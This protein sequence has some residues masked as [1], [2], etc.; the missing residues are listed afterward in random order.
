MTFAGLAPGMIGMYQVDI[1]IPADIAAPQATLS[2]VD[3]FPPTGVVGDF[4]T[5]F[6]AAH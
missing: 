6:I 1:A 4:G 2:C 3:Q 5:L